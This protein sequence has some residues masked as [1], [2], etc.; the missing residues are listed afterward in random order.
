M[1][2]GAILVKEQ[3]VAGDY[4]FWEFWEQNGYFARPPRHDEV[5]AAMAP[6]W[7]E[8]AW[9]AHSAHAGG[10]D[11]AQAVAEARIRVAHLIGALPSEIVFTAG[12]TEAN[13][14]AI[15]GVAAAAKD[16]LPQRRRIPLWVV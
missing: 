1:T 6:F 7:S 9:N 14:I 4:V 16:E 10:A 12:A 13:N 2:H 8:R 3:V 15:L 11:A 5:I